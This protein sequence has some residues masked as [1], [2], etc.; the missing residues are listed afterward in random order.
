MC[1]VNVDLLVATL[2]FFQHLFQIYASSRNKAKLSY[3]HWHHSN[4]SALFLKRSLCLVS[5]S[6]CNMQ[7]ATLTYA[8]AEQ[9]KIT[10]WSCV[11]VSSSYLIC[12]IYGNY[13]NSKSRSVSRS[14][15]WFVCF[16]NL[17]ILFQT[18]NG[19]VTNFT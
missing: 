13:K 6:G 10:Q 8:A 14:S 15:Q 19:M 16:E 3:T 9:F 1:E 11:H 17:E 7:P 4:S 18:F 2:I 5:N 12:I